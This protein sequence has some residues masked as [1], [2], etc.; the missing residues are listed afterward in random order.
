MPL[1]L[2]FKATHVPFRVALLSVFL[3][4]SYL[5]VWPI[6]SSEATAELVRSVFVNGGLLLAIALALLALLLCAMLLQKRARIRLERDPVSDKVHG[7][8][9]LM[10]NGVLLANMLLSMGEA[11]R[12]GDRT[13][14]LVADAL[15]IVFV[16][17]QAAYVMQL[18]T[19][20]FDV[21]EVRV[22]RSLRRAF[23]VL[24]YALA[25]ANLLLW[26]LHCCEFSA[27][28]PS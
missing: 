9:L 18:F 20:K 8:E 23:A 1:Q 4:A 14:A 27:P 19:Y 11:I 6:F 15:F 7:S 3:L 24:L 12:N 28:N 21:E 10:Y 17:L 26:Y 5:L 25:A 13:F 2:L 22:R 16:A